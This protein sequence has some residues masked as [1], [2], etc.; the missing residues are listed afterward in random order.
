MRTKPLHR[1]H[2]VMSV[3]SDEDFS[4][5]SGVYDQN[6]KLLEQSDWSIRLERESPTFILCLRQQ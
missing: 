5:Y 4:P 2:S 1:R 3:T 6:E